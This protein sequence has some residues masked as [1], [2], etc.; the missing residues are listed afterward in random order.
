M[1]NTFHVSCRQWIKYVQ[2]VWPCFFYTCVDPK[3]S[4]F[5][6]LQSTALFFFIADVLEF[7]L[8]EDVNIACSHNQ[9]ILMTSARYG[10][11]R[12]GRCIS[13]TH[14]RCS[15]DALTELDK[16]C[17]GQ[18]SCTF[19]VVNLT[20]LNPCPA[21]VTSYLEISYSCVTGIMCSCHV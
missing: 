3:H 9:V 12:A 18:P 1:C 17:S 10:R 11:M 7:C 8:S 15:V 4:Y 14:L 5:E 13:A 21:D 2:V 16:L 20:H 19:P 6:I